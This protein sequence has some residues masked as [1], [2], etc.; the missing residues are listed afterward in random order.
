M[1]GQYYSNGDWS[2]D[3]PKVVGPA[4]LGFWSATSVFD[5]ARSIAGCAPDLDRHCAR[6]I[7]SAEA[8]GLDPDLTAVQV[9]TLCVEG[10]QALPADLDLYVRPMFYSFGAGIMPEEAETR[11]TLAVFE[12]PLPD[13]M[14]GRATVT[15]QRRPAP[16]Q[17]P[18]DSKAGALY[19][20]SQRARREARGR[21]FELAVV[22]DPDG[23]LAEFSHANLAIAKDGVAITPKPNGSFL[24]GITRNRTF[25]LL[26]EAGVS[27]EERVMTVADLETA[28][29]IFMCG[30]AGKVQ[31]VTG[32]EERDLQ[33]GPVFRKARDLYTAFVATQRV[34]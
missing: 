5:G 8:V 1:K 27:T 33:P 7:R 31:A 19:P 6:L 14:A 11:F 25:E 30:N 2:N 12:M 34:H 24:N 29:E 23:N 17:G 18:T 13:A 26:R 28:D 20:N 3:P 15:A 32:F 22:L 21:G 9:H 16:D 4:D 10:I